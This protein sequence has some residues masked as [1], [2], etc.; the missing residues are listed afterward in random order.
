MKKKLPR[1][2]EETRH[3]FDASLSGEPIPITIEEIRRWR[4]RHISKTIVGPELLVTLEAEFEKA[5]AEIGNNEHF[6]GLCSDIEISL[7]AANAHLTLLYRAQD[8]FLSATIEAI[9]NSIGAALSFMALRITL[10]Q[11]K[12][13]GAGPATIGTGETAWDCIR[14]EYAKNR[15]R[16]A[17][18]VYDD[19][20]RHFRGRYPYLKWTLARS[21][22][23]RWFKK[24][25]LQG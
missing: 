22:A 18:K 6:R 11:F 23:L 10:D 8:P 19:T 12:S 1:G 3:R 20:V 9:N 5:K 16:S 15:Q 14:A 24:Q 2:T 7:G 17:G 25:V 4:A 13:P 21:T